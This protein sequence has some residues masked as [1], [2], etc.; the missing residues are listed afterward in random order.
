M[1]VIFF[2]S[3][4]I[5]V[6]AVAAIALGYGA[7]CAIHGFLDILLCIIYVLVVCLTVGV[8]IWR[9]VGSVK[10]TKKQSTPVLNVF[11]TLLSSAFLLYVNHII[12]TITR[13]SGDGL[14]GAFLFIF[15]ILFGG[16]IWLAAIVGWRMTIT[17]ENDFTFDN[18]KG[19]L[20]SACSAL[21][22]AWWL[23]L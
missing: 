6:F 3:T 10:G 9:I 2:S 16:A 23:S 21:F 8:S 22:L 15:N 17:F 14:F 19:F 12:I 11:M 5:A 4:F 1:Y 18:F 13:S 20:M 7:F